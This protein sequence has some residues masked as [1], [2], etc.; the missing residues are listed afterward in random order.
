MMI[1]TVVVVVAV[2]VAIV[3]TMHDFREAVNTLCESI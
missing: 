1:I 2:A 3:I